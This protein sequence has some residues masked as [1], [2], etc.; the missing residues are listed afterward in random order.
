MT[1]KRTMYHTYKRGQIILADFKPSVGNELKGMHFAIVI[2]KND[3]PNNGVVTVIPL[4]SKNKNYYVDLGDFLID[5][6]FDEMDKKIEEIKNANTDELTINEMTN[7]LAVLGSINLHAEN[8][9]KRNK[10]TYA[11]VQNISS[12][13]KFKIKKYESNY[14]PLKHIRLSN[15]LFNKIDSKIIELYTSLKWF[16]IEISQC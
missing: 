4:S 13:S 3:S 16:D 5:S 2:S 6:I 10:T 1:T 8:Y 9:L 11:M 12:I 7:R 14:D 15:E